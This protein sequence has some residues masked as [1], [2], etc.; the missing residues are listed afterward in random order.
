MSMS[1]KYELPQKGWGL[2]KV[3]DIDLVEFLDRCLMYD[4]RVL[5]H[6]KGHPYDETTLLI[7]YPTQ[8]TGV[9]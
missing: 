5:Y 1:Q 6:E 8:S 2:L 7:R 9:R 4:F 3:R